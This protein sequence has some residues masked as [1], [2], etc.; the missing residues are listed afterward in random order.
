MQ[1]SYLPTINYCSDEV[2]KKRKIIRE[3]IISTSSNINCGKII[4]LS[5]EDLKIIFNLYDKHFLYSYFSNDFNGKLD[6]SLSKK[7]TKSAG[8]TVKYKNT[9]SRDL[10]EKYEI[11]IGIN[12]FLKFDEL[13]REKRV[14]GIIAED[15]LDALMLVMEHEIC[16]L[17]EFHVYGRSNCSGKRYK[18]IS[19][20]IFMHSSRYHQL[21]T[22]E[23]ILNEKKGLRIGDRVC[24]I[25]N[26]II[27]EGIIYGINVRATVM[28]P[29]NRGRY[30]D[31][32]GARYEKWYVPLKKL[33]TVS[34]L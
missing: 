13:I 5:A 11:K 20:N 28:V 21:P 8:A 19:S 24:F 33:N 27:V 2:H 7:M 17:I 22:N 26:Q 18:E 3:E 25:H 34:Q 9:Q 12:F 4:S 14:N 1:K 10:L 16:H 23:E 15:S 29:D 32:S 6:F 30:S 31:S